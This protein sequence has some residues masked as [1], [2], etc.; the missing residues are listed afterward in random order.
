MTNNLITYI[1]WALF[2]LVTIIGWIR[3]DKQTKKTATD[4]AEVA[5]EIAKQ[6]LNKLENTVKFLP[7]VRDENYREERGRLLQKVDNLEKQLETVLFL[8]RK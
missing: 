3:I 1:G 7:C 8:L 5:K 4:A 2:L 6:E